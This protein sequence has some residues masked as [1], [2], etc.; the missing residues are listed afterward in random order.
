MRQILLALGLAVTSACSASAD[1]PR[2]AR[3]EDFVGPKADGFCVEAGSDEAAGIL[4]LVNDPATTLALLDDPTSEGGAG[5]NR[6]A[7]ENI[8]DER[9]FAALAELDGVHFVGIATCEALRD[10]ACEVRDLCVASSCDA[11][12]FQPAPASTE[13]DQHCADAMVAVASADQTE[14]SEI[15]VDVANRCEQLDVDQRIAFDIAASEFGVPVADLADE[16]FSL[17]TRRIV[18]EGRPL[19]VF[20]VEDLHLGSRW[21]MVFESDEPL[22]MLTSDGL[23]FFAEAYCGRG[24]S[25]VDFGREWCLQALLESPCAAA[26]RAARSTS[27]TVADALTDELFIRAAARGYRARTGVNDDQLLDFAISSCP[28]DKSA[29]VTVSGGPSTTTFHFSESLFGPQLVA[30]G[31]AGGDTE[32]ACEPV[33]P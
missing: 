9:P 15:D 2:D 32:L 25:P 14:S 12:A 20:E 31:A 18:A 1:E 11:E 23:G 27:L 4:S 8:V 33:D 21:W 10:F 19:T 7:A 16:R 17:E 29:R 13:F 22:L 28:F 5:L 3:D 6:I 26:E 30:V 24:A